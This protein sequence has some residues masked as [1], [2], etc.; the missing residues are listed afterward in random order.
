M[1]DP[2]SLWL[3]Q[4]V[5]SAPPTPD[6]LRDRANRFE[7]QIR[8]RNMIEYVA[9]V[10][11]FVIFGVYI[12]VIPEPIIK[13]ASAMIIIGTAYAMMQLYR[14]ASTLKPDPRAPA[15]TAIA[16]HRAQLER[17]RKAVE[18]IWLWYLGPMAPGLLL[19]I[20]G[21]SFIHSSLSWSD[22]WRVL[23]CGGVFGAVWWL[24]W[25]AG[26][27]LRREIEKL[28]ALSKE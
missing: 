4:D 8:V 7:K 13:V 24:N 11:V 20:L 25:R 18:G 14:R 21:P 23:V 9:A 19:F 17:Q 28:D 10:L 1:T 22:F 15:A 2:K 6:Q 27:M 16:F 26:R 3:H 5:T 12:V